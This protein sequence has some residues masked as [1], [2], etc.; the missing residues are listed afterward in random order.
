MINYEEE[1]K[2]FKPVQDVTDAEGAIYNRELTDVMDLMKE[3][4]KETNP[5]TRRK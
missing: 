3:I 4:L 1:L 5:G 2:K